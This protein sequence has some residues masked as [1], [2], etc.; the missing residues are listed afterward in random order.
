MLRTP[1][2][3]RL[4]AAPGVG[5]RRDAAAQTPPPRP[6][7][8]ARGACPRAGRRRAVGQDALRRRSVRALPDGR[9][10]AVPARRG[11]PRGAPALLPPELDRGLVGREGAQRLERG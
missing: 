10:V 5:I 4:A 9:P 7:R 6:A 3:A 8:G 1:A 2:T 11:R